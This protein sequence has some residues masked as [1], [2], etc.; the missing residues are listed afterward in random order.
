M[1]DDDDCA[2]ER[3]REKRGGGIEVGRHSG[4]PI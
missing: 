1:A 3:Q 2:C 4:S